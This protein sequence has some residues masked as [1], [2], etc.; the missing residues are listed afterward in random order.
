[1]RFLK[2][3]S[4]VSFTFILAVSSY[5]I[6]KQSIVAYWSCDEGSGN[7]VSS[8]IGNYAGTLMVGP[9]WKGDPH[10][11][12]WGEGKFGKGLAFNSTK[13][14]F[15]LV[16]TDDNMDKL[17]KP[18]S[19]FTVAY[20]IKTTKTSGKG[21]T[22]D[23]GSS[24]WTQG[25]HCAIVNGKPFSEGCDNVAPGWQ[26]SAGKSVA[27]DQ[28]HHVAH[29]FDVGKKASIYV[30]GVLDGQADISGDTDIA[31]VGWDLVF[32]TVG[33]IENPWHE[34]LDGYI[35]DIV[36]FDKVLSESEIKELT[37]GPVISQPSA[38]KPLGKIAT[39]WAEFKQ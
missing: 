16:K 12:G 2:L 34:F 20:W 21:R 11:E 17:G 23:K 15:V 9:G 31:G 14:W 6:D 36:I 24:G 38:V 5:A 27:D 32:G 35:D 7:K 1:M 10:Q 37:A 33:V 29:I 30:D 3:L 39:K 13:E 25:W 18:D 26:A 8:V 28:W 22:I 4:V 19:A